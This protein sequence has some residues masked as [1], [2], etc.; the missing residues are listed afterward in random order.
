MEWCN[1]NDEAPNEDAEDNETILMMDDQAMATDYAA[2]R[3]GR[4]HALRPTR[5][6]E[7][8][9]KY[10]GVTGTVLGL[11]LDDEVASSVT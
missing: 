3:A 4:R 6:R 7:S 9:S 11:Q 5:R 2:I 8:F 1:N 10:G